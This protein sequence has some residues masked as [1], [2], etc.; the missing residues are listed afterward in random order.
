MLFLLATYFD[1]SPHMKLRVPQMY[2]LW[3]SQRIIA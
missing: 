2:D 1:G 3:R